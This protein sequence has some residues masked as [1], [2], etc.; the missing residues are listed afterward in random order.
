VRHVGSSGHFGPHEPGELP[1][2]GGDH[3][4]AVGF[5]FVEATEPAAQADLGRP[6]PGHHT[7]VKAGLT[8]TELD[9]RA[10]PGAVRPRRFDQ[11]GA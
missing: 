9:P 11:L 3:D 5:A 4:V 1:G 6:R 8:A 2:D 7:G 10:G